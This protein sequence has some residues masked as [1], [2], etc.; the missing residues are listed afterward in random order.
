MHQIPFGC[1][2]NANCTDMKKLFIAIQQFE[3]LDLVKF[4]ITFSPSP[5]TF[6]SG[7]KTQVDYILCRRGV[8]KAVKDC[9][10]I[11]GESVAKQHKLVVSRTKIGVIRRREERRVKKTRW[12][13]LEDATFWEKFVLR[14]ERKMYGELGGGQRNSK[15]CSQSSTGG[16]VREWK[17]ED[18]DLVVV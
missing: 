9:K 13:K 3:F 4:R 18:G 10:V 7:G 16:N 14:V 2:M 8:L 15:E 1:R 11:P 17:R 12:W 6:T 5:C